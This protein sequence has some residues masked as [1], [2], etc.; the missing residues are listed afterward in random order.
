M[1]GK[2]QLAWRVHCA[3]NG[4]MSGPSDLQARLSTALSPQWLTLLEGATRAARRLGLP[5]YLV[6]GAVRDLLMGQTIMDLDLVVEGDAGL[7]ATALAEALAGEVLARSQ[8]GTARL[9]VLGQRIDVVTARRETYRRH[10]ALPTVQPGTMD[11]DLGRRDFT[12]NAMALRLEPEPVQLLDPTDGQRDIQGKLVRVLHP[13]SFQDDATRIL[14]AVRYERRLGFR[15]E[16]DTETLLRRD[17]GMLD[18]IGGDRLRRELDLIFH[19]EQ[20][21]P[22]LLRVTDLGVLTAL[23]SPLPDALALE[24]RLSRFALADGMA[25]PH[26]Y[27]ALLA[28]SLRRDQAEAFVRRLNMPATWARVVWDVALARDATDSLAAEASPVI[29]FRLLNELGLE[30]VQVAAALAS[31]EGARNNLQRYLQE[32]RHVRPLLNGRDLVRLGVPLGPQVGEMLEALRYARLEGRV[33][34][35]EQEETLVRER[36][37]TATP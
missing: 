21:R 25:Q 13:A 30:A 7:L 23:F 22:M 19:E 9:R 32:W 26:H 14:R 8:F 10:G 33:S 15:L 17:L 27:L 37:S 16:V 3:Y 4:A 35:R 24:Q 12:I 11:D 28:Y 31:S 2:K 36:V 34:T 1:G 20:A 18:T 5:L 6:G 29:V